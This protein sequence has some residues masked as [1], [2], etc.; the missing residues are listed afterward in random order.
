MT[1]CSQLLNLDDKYMVIIALFFQLFY[2]FE[3][4]ILKCWKIKFKKITHIPQ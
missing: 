3:N 2:I 1:K 4:F